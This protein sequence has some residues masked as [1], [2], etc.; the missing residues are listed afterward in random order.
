M[1]NNEVF[2]VF[3]AQFIRPEFRERFIHEA[4]KKPEKLLQRVCHNIE[5]LFLPSFAKSDS[6]VVKTGTCYLLH[7]PRGF[8]ETSWESASKIIGIGDGCLVIDASGNM[9]YAES[10][11]V[12]GGPSVVYSS[13]I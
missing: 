10:E 5:E 12:K 11:A 7:G 8:R 4:T 1:V 2:S 6:P 9:F 3:A 13:G